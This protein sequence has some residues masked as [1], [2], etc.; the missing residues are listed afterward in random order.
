MKEGLHLKYSLRSILQ[1]N[2]MH[3]VF[4]LRAHQC[5]QVGNV[6]LDSKFLSIRS[7]YNNDQYR[8][9]LNSFDYNLKLLNSLGRC[10]V[11]LG[12]QVEEV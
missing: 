9:D 4:S 7:I 1:K 8:K 6:V 11:G 3:G 2:Q 10:V 5:L 12:L